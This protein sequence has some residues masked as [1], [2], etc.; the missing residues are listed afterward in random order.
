MP[1]YL[2]GDNV[3]QNC[4]EATHVLI[5]A[6]SIANRIVDD[7]EGH[8]FTQQGLAQQWIFHRGEMIFAK[9]VRIGQLN[10]YYVDYKNVTNY[11]LKTAA[12][13]GATISNN[14]RHG[15][16]DNQQDAYTRLVANY[17]DTRKWIRDNFTY[18][19]NMEKE[20]Y[21]ITQYHHTHVRLKDLFPSRKI[22]KL[23]GYE[24]LLAMM[25]D[26]FNNI[27]STHVTFFTYLRALPDREKEIF[28]SLVLNYN[29]LGREWLKTEGVRAK[30]AQ[31]TVKYDMSKLFELNVLE[32]RV[33]E[34]VDWEK[35]KRNRT[36]IKTVDISYAKVLEHCRELFIMAR[37]EGKRPM[38]MKWQ[39]Y[40][41]QR[42]V[43]M[44]G[45][46]VHSQHPVE[47]D[48]IRVL[49]REIK[50]KKG[51]ASVMPY[52]EQKYFTSRRP[53]IHAYTSTK[54]EWGKVRAL[55]G[56]DFSSHTMADFGLLQCED[57]FPGFVPTGS[58]A[59][60]D[61]VRTR[62]A[63][64]HSLIPF[65]YDF[66]DFNS[67]HSK[68][69][70]QAVID[71]WISVYHDKLT[72]DQ[73]EAAKWTRNSVDRMVA[74]QTNTGETYD[75][76][77]T[78]FS[79][80]RLTTFIN[81]ALNYCYLANAG[82]NSLVPTSLHNGDD[83][84]AGI[85]T[86][87]DGISLI[88]NAAATGVRANTT[89]MNIGTIAEFLRV[90]MR[91]KNN[92]GSQYLTRG[93]ATFTHSRVESDAP[94]TLRNLVSAYKTRYD[95]ILARG[96]SI[97]NMK[98]L[99]RKQLFFARKLFNV[100]KDIVDNLITM[101][102]SCGGLQEKGR[103]SEIVLREVDIE[104]IDSY[105]KTRMIAKLID[106]GV[107]DYT[108]FLKTNFSEIADAITKK[109]VVESLTKAYNVKKKTVVSAFRDLSAAYHERAVRHAWKGMS[110]LHIVNRI[111]MGVSNLVMVVSKINPAKANVLA[112]SGDPTKWLAVLT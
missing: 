58:Y 7:G 82:I 11:S 73:I 66:D 31:G 29:G 97:D 46:S 79:G 18:N 78:L 30:Q 107:G 69:A 54:Y 71:A 100:E 95:E 93:I 101:D 56:C 23:E 64:T 49:P 50:S 99:Y 8:C 103:V 55:Y 104:N 74:H 16:V 32:N 62:I 33:D 90:D 22:V 85:R 76:K 91:A 6:C 42:A 48:V 96:A 36:D 87:A 47:Q 9:A 52:K 27:E 41:R 86:I 60:E 15:F 24:A 110:G 10:A 105:K 61:Y 37:A 2:N 12:Q 94:L 28:I 1:L 67:Q 80:W 88:K 81:T 21:R 65:C 59:N 38:R 57:T 83:V 39:E 102:I 75:V 5:K 77:G 108:A 111:R 14:L 19:Y 112:K 63:G 45:G 26:R 4:L 72:D 40:W 98:P 35:E 34:E 13:V 70:M 92:T 89:K 43:V 84:F 3:A 106:K 68:E 109:H 51:L 17:S 44:P 20:K 53:E 25:L